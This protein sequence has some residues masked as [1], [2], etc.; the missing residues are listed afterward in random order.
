MPFMM[1]LAVREMRMTPAEALFAATAGGARALQRDDIGTLSA[2]A[3]AD[4]VVLGAPSYLHL[5]YRPGSNL[6]EQSW[7]AGRRMGRRSCTD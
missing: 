6:V 5:A 2:G 3:R 7:I 1:A 4:F